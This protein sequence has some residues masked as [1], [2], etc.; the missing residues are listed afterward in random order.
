MSTL[1]VFGALAL[2]IILILSK[3]PIAFSLGLTGVAGLLALHGVRD[4]DS[5]VS[6][7]PFTS[8]ASVSLAVV[9]MFI[10]M[11]ML[12][13][14]AG[15]PESIFRLANKVLRRVP[16][17]L[18]IATIF[19][20]AGFAA[21]TGSSIASAATMGKLSIGEMLKFGYSKQFS[22]G[23]VATA[24]TLGV[25]IPPSVILVF[26]GI[27]TGESIGSLL[28]AGI[29]PGLLS[30]V[31][32]AGSIL[33]RAKVSPASIYATQQSVPV[34]TSV[35]SG[36]PAIKEVDDGSRA[37][38]GGESSTE[39]AAE[40]ITPWDMT[41]HTS[42][43]ILIFAVV[44]GGIYSGLFT[45]T[46]SGA[47][48]AV[49]L[50]LV[51]LLEKARYGIKGIAGAFAEALKGTASTSA[52]MLA[53][54]V[55]A[56]FFS[57]FLVASGV[58]DQFVSWM[59]SLPIAP[60]LLMALLIM[61]L[62]ALGTILETLSLILITM[63][64]I[65]PVAIGLGFDGLWLGIVAAKAIEIG[66]LTPPVGMNVY[67]V[68]GS[69]RKISVEDGFRGVA[70]FIVIELLILALLFMFPEIVLFLPHQS[71]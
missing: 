46:E 1:I 28:L 13:S 20:G 26:Y 67:V 49:L 29:I 37:T 10:M 41:R 59:V 47:I 34:A 39:S 18:G 32:F 54:V 51:L 43:L 38:P 68:A 9:P 62:V 53:I 63:P 52:M 27:V 55:G 70:P 11:G 14:S 12:A 45:A 60:T 42:W 30:A 65:Y 19:A 15:L 23:V 66:L 48:G 7:I 24:G 61:I 57:T 33:I 16:G 56:T 17:G 2:L 25:L 44:I 71:S 6:S 50:C 69:H 58:T 35:S 5:Y 22:A 31:V 21:V 40:T 3:V 8:M 4:A 36:T 64:L